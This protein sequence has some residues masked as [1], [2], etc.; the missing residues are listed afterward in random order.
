MSD[1]PDLFYYTDFETF[2]L[3]IANG[4]L[5]FKESTKSN[6]KLDTNI[7]YA[8]L[9][10]IFDERYGDKSPQKQFLNNYYEHTG[11]QSNSVSV[12]ACF[13]ER[14]DSR[15]LWDA[16]TMHRADRKAERY[17]GVCIQINVDN[18][19]NALQRDCEDTDLFII[20]GVLYDKESRRNF[21]IHKLDEFDRNV[22]QLSRDKDQT[23]NIVPNTRVIYPSGK[24]GIEITLKKCIV[25]PMMKFISDVQLMS[26][27]YKHEFWK[28]EAETRAM[29]CKQKESLNKYPNG[30]HY[31][32]AHITNDCI[33]KVILGP[34]FSEEDMQELEAQSNAIDVSS[35]NFVNSLGKGV[36]TSES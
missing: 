36:I 21:L 16:Y 23:Q 7:L 29:F 15:L 9:K 11:Y 26:P 1:F 24:R 18:I 28:E 30:A 35:I 5:R 32:D 34:E 10:E 12:V 2:K 13:T 8:E 6:D 14:G 25:V 20:K 33:E 19:A 17:N 31:F 4:T 22:E 3:I 27:L